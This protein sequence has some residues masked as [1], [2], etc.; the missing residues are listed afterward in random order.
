M[1]YI[2]QLTA[3]FCGEGS[4]YGGRNGTTFNRKGKP[5]VQSKFKRV[6]IIKSKSEL[7]IL[8]NALS[9]KHPLTIHDSHDR[10]ALGL[11]FYNTAAYQ[12]TLICEV[13]FASHFHT[14]F[15]SL[16]LFRLVVATHW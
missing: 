13:F 5:G 10:V 1:L 8:L 11:A 2:L 9:I 7:L 4:T 6:R 3:V 14:P 12:D 15:I 16:E